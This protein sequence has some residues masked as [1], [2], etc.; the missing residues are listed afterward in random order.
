MK[1]DIS[2]M[3]FYWTD[4]I[5]I[6]CYPFKEQVHMYSSLKGKSNIYNTFCILPELSI[7]KKYI[8]QL[9]PESSWRSCNQSWN[10]KAVAG[11]TRAPEKDKL[12][13]CS[14]YFLAY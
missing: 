4:Q 7:F 6:E 8:C 10:E 11:R 13:H 3:P 5:Y 1:D 12:Y 14:L 9:C 2:K